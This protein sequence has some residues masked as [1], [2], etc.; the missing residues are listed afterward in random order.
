MLFFSPSFKK[1]KIIFADDCG[2]AAAAAFGDKKNGGGHYLREEKNDFS[3]AMNTFEYTFV[4][5][6]LT[7]LREASDQLIGRRHANKARARENTQNF[8]LKSEKK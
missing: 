2:T 6:M 4:R 5:E 1:R 7:L 3:F 8:K